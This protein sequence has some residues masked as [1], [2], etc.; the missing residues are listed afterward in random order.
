MDIDPAVRLALLH[1]PQ[2]Q[3]AMETL[4]LS[5]LDVSSERFLFDSQFYGGWQANY[6]SDGPRRR[7]AGGES[8]STFTTGPSSRAPRAMVMTKQFSTGADLLVGMANT[9]TWQLAGPNNQSSNTLLDFSLIQPLLAQGGR[10]VVLERLT[11]S[12]RQLLSNIRA[13]E[14]YRRSFYMQGVTGRN[15]TPAPSRR[16]GVAGGAGLS[17]FTGLGGGFGTLGTGGG[18][19][20]QGF[21][22]NATP[23]AGGYLN[24]LQQ[25]LTIINTRENIIRQQDNLMRLEDTYRE[26][27]LTIPEVQT[28]ISTQQLQVAQQQQSI[29]SIQTNLLATTV[30]YEQTM[31]A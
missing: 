7:G 4:F 9:M 29:F 16:G 8:S 26:L 27:L 24:L 11:L 12:E 3:Q 5:A 23:G 10:D 1:S 22:A 18:G 30:S 20:N 25:Q 15:L 21:N 13:F 19:G 2:Y 17:G 6:L 28:T 31:D 14:R